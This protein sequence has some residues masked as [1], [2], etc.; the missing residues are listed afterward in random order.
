MKDRIEQFR[1]LPA[2]CCCGDG[3]HLIFQN[4]DFELWQIVD[5]RAAR[6]CSEG[7]AWC[8]LERDCFDWYRKQGPIFYIYSNKRKASYILS[9]ATREFKNH[10]NRSKSLTDFVNNHQSAFHQLARLFIHGG[11][12]QGSKLVSYYRKW[13]SPLILTWEE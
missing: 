8:L 3:F 12:E 1:A 2:G 7:T 5:Y 11:L 13:S 4:L 10:R 6:T 9:P